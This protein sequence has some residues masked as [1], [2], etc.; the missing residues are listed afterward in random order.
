MDTNPT[1]APTHPT[2]L[3][4]TGRLTELAGVLGVAL[5]QWSTRD[6]SKAQP[7]V[8]QGANTA[9]EAIDAMLAEL[10]TLRAALVGEIRR[11]DDTAGARVDAMLAG[12]DREESASGVPLPPGIEGYAPGQS[13]GA[14]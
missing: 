3:D 10:H 6:D 9:M 14:R 7:A 4:V 11:S 13:G 2:L 5:A 1:P 12:Y 8:R